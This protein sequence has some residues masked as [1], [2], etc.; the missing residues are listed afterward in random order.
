MQQGVE[1]MKV[2]NQATMTLKLGLPGLLR[3][4]LKI[5]HKN[6]KFIFFTFLT[7][8]PLFCT[9]LPHEMLFQRALMEAVATLTVRTEST[10][11]IDSPTYYADEQLRTIE[12]LVWS[13][14]H[15]FLKLALLYL[16]PLHVCDLLSILAT[17]DSASAIYAGEEGTDGVKEMVQRLITRTRWKGPFITS[18]F[19]LTMSAVILFEIIFIV[20]LSYY[21]PG[22]N[23]S[24]L[25]YGLLNAA[26]YAACFLVLFKKWL[27][28]SAVWNMGVVF[29]ILGKRHGIEALELSAYFSNGSCRQLG[30]LLMLGLFVWNLGLRLS[31]FLLLHLVGRQGNQWT[32]ILAT[33]AQVSLMCLGNVFKWVTFMVYYYDCK[34]RFSEKK[35]HVEEASSV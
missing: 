32:E 2:D 27:E 28:W 18:I 17:V 19:V 33:S 30:F 21:A 11:S 15:Q 16:F 25:L 13:M 14:S 24:E 5:F 20:A 29:S 23:L 22:I 8:I 7:S 1:M 35:I 10:D 26:L 9:M 4:S 31:C 3:E 34:N 12:G 6:P